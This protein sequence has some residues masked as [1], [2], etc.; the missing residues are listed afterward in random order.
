MEIHQ[1]FNPYMLKGSLLKSDALSMANTIKDS[2]KTRMIAI[3]AADGVNENSLQYVKE[4]LE[5]EGAK[6]DIIA[7]KL[8]MLTGEGKTEIAANQSLLTASSVL[9][10]AVYVPGGINSVA[11]LAAEPDAIHFLNEAYKHCKAIAADASAMQVLESTYFYKKLPPDNSK[12]TALTEG[13][14]IQKDINKLSTQF[15]AAVSQHRFW[16][17][18][19]PKKVP[20]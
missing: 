10:D 11:T 3:L 7:P 6:V 12:E 8:G 18:E 9:Y 13:I 1:N 16:E 15:I 17:R 4:A 5:T 20:A 14:V 2:I 19:K